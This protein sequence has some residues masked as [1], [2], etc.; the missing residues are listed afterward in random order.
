MLKIGVCVK[1]VTDPEAPASTFKIAAD[2]LHVMPATGVPPVINPYDE[3][4]LEAAL[5]LKDMAIPFWKSRLAPQSEM[6]FILAF[7]SCL[8][9]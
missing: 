9:F 5:K 2:G 7:I 6:N 4:A 3:N 8:Y 1:V